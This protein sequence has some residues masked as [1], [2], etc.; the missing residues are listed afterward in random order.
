LPGSSSGSCLDTT[1]KESASGMRRDRQQE[2]RGSRDPSQHRSAQSRDRQQEP[3]C[4]RDPSQLGSAQS[5]DRQ[6]EPRGSR[7]PSQH[8]SAQSCDRSRKESV[9]GTL[10]A[11]GAPPVLSRRGRDALAFKLFIHIS[12][13]EVEN[14]GEI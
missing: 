13:E 11:V 14:R 1:L 7:D 12:T 2:P 10:Y 5:R 9:S 3:R 8:G 6:Q 4:S